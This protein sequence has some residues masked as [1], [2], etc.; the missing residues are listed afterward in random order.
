M[1]SYVAVTEV[2]D[3]SV[4][5]ARSRVGEESVVHVLRNLVALDVGR[6]D[7]APQVDFTL[8]LEKH[9][10]FSTR[11]SAQSSQPEAWDAHSKISRSKARPPTL[12][13]RLEGMRHYYTE[14]ALLELTQA[15]ATS[16]H[17]DEIEL[18]DDAAEVLVKAIELMC[19]RDSKL[20]RGILTLADLGCP[21]PSF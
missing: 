11:K 19:R 1:A 18:L 3:R 21:D 17:Q 4:S 16:D 6:H 2:R 13:R 8:R 5:L 14:K 7:P 10:Q 20:I 15:I 12:G 9:L